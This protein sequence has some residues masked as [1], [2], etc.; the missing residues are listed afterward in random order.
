MTAPRHRRGTIYTEAV[1]AMT[2][3]ISHPEPPTTADVARELGTTESELSDLFPEDGH[4]LAAS[5]ENAVVLLH[6]QCVKSV[7]KVDPE[8]PLAQFM[9]LSDAYIEWA[10]Q[11]PQEF[12]I[13]GTIPAG[14]TP[15]GGNILR[16][17]RALHELMTRFLQQAQSKGLLADNADLPLIIATSRSFA[18]GVANKMLSGNLTRWMQGEPGLDAA[19]RA[20]HLFTRSM[21][22]RGR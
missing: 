22:S 8:D 7:V 14:K 12:V 15:V 13:L 21:I 20:L 9:A 18:F 1:S 4:L 16:Y 5:L 2:R 3:L 19:R 11:H 6:D 10:S 17:E